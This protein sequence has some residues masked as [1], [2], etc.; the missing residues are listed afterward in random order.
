MEYDEELCFLSFLK[1]L[2]KIKFE[3]DPELFCQM[4]AERIILFKA[5]VAALGS[6]R[7]ELHKYVEQITNMRV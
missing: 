5:L 7:E 4:H 2:C 6:D 3:Y 1:N